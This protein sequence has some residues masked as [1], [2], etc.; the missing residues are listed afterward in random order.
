MKKQFF[1]LCFYII[2]VGSVQAQELVTYPAPQGVVY[3]QHNDDYTV[4]VRKPG[5]EWQDLF[6]YNVQVDL[7]K[8]QDA[9]MVYFDH[10]GAV[11]VA[12]R[13]NNGSVQSVE[14]RPSSYGIHPA[15]QGNTVFFTLAKPSKVSVEFNGD[16][17]HNLHVFGNAMEKEKPNPKDTN[18]IYFG[19]GVHQP[20]DLPGDEIN[21]P[22]GKTVYIA[23][24][25]V[26]K[27]KLVCDRVSNVK[28]MG[29]GILLQPQRGVEVRHSTNV[30]IEGII[31]VNPKHYTVYGG[32]ANK[33]TIRNIKSFSSNGWSDG[34]DLMSCSDVTID[35]VF[36][37]NSDDCIAI[38]GHRWDY[39]GDVRNYS[40]TNSTLWADIAHPIN[41]GL[42]GNT[43]KEGEVIE[44]LSFKNI[45]ILEQDEDDPDYQGCMAISDGDLNLVQN[46][47]FE[48]IRI[49]DFQEGQL[50]NLR[51]VNNAKYNTGPGRGIRNITFRNINYKGINLNPSLIQGLDAG[52]GI[53]NITIEEL[54]IN[55]KLVKD[56]DEANIKIGAFTQGVVFTNGKENGVS[57]AGAQS[58]A[59]PGILHSREDLERMRKAVANREEPVFSGYQVFI[60][61]PA[62]QYT[63]QM[64]GPLEIVGRNPTVGQ[65]TY[66]SDANAAH[67]NA[68]MWAITG[69][70]RY[71]DKAI[72]IVNAW[73]KTLKSITGRDAVLMAG[74]GP[75]KMV[76]A[77]EILR[78]TNSGWAET[79]IQQSEKH[80]RE[81]IY[82]VIKDFAPFANGNW[83]AAAMK[84]VMAIGVFCN[85]RQLFEKA[86]RYYVAGHG[87]GSLTHYIIN[88]E[89]QIQES[90]RDQGHTQL[91]IGMLAECSEIAWKQGLDL[92]AYHNNRLLKGFE[93]V[94]KFNLGD[95]V[96]FTE[97][98]DRTGKYFHINI[99]RQDRGPLRAV[100]E[101]VFNHYVNRI[102]IQAP[103]TRQAAEKIRPEGPGKPGA[104]HPGYGTLFFT[105]PTER[106]G[107]LPAMVPAAPGGLI[108][109]GSS[110]E[111][112]LT[113]IASIGATSYTVKRAA[114]SSGPYTV[115][116]KNV[117]AA[118]YTDKDVKAGML[119]YYTVSASNA[120]G[121]SKNAMET[122]IAAGLPNLWKQQ[123]IG[124]VNV[125]GFTKYDGQLFTIEGSG[126][127]IDSSID[128]FHYAYKPVTGSGEITVRFV[129]QPSSQFSRMGVMMR[130]RLT[131][132]APHVSLLLYPGK[133]G[134][135]E[136]PKWH[137][138][139]LARGKAREQTAV[140]SSGTGLSEPSVTYGRFTGYCWLRLQRKGDTFT[141]FSS[142]DGK[143]WTELGSVV[144][145]VK[146]TLFVGLLV[147]SGMPNSTTIMFDRV[148]VQAAE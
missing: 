92:Y 140:K 95:E 46:I 91:G 112:T 137:V 131:A 1:L 25:A 100:Y 11:E 63:Y 58:F 135:T 71:A 134:Q 101:Q 35:D 10:L 115:I 80:F 85:D 96:P 77:A 67:Q 93:Y 36:M 61:N 136:A 84:T 55:G 22:S 47:S 97:S 108:A 124:I 23:G 119:Y 15:V 59:H 3:L 129:P 50:L 37:R 113:W 138:R 43:E 88:D 87:N 4:K 18:V 109:V 123:D 126:M 121:E 7:D 139:L 60:Q 89:G 12:V 82:P 52:H 145:P 32:G 98:L 105:I 56:E 27:A 64:Q 146:K 76:N 107:A 34:I 117:E 38:Y 16:K 14:V 9:S 110:K 19:P 29:R 86:L 45:D 70:R 13:K 147:A 39:Y 6:E 30:S 54:S 20:K 53:Q 2:C 42:H 102:G 144:V 62:S 40:V 148:R 31:I 143:S 99:A 118:K 116:A 68:V 120:N 111:N 133:T 104:D 8:P 114:K 94:A 33:L 128:A 72:E 75:F 73:S 130:E 106:T 48:D 122:G 28:I 103:F 26:V 125:P 79:D 90:G 17:L 49:E 74:L 57:R 141:G 21:I 78:Y 132:D 83:D 51:V 142:I 127:G 24:G 41:I 66:D 44:N 69:D 65:G 81:V 5:G